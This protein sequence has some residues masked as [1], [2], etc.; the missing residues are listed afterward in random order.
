M[1]PDKS[2]ETQL[3]LLSQRVLVI[4]RQMEKMSET[5]AAQS[6]I[7]IGILAAVTTSAVMLAINLAIQGL[8]P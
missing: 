6:K 8:Q 4:E 1:S 5:M 7:L 3:A 2:V